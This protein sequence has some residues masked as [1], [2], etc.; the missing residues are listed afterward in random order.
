MFSED[1]NFDVKNKKP[2]T[3]LK[4]LYEAGLKKIEKLERQKIKTVRQGIDA[5]PEFLKPACQIVSALPSTQ[6]SAVERMFFQLNLLL[7]EN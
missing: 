1:E 4:M 6:D 3:P 2:D 7:R 5:Y